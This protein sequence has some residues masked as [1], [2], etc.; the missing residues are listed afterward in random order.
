MDIQLRCY[1][2]KTPGKF[3]ATSKPSEKFMAKVRKEDIILYFVLKKGR[4]NRYAIN[5]NNSYR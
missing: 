3:S 2:V 5:E 4:L 1:T